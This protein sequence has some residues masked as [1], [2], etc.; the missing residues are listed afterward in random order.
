MGIEG[1]KYINHMLKSMCKTTSMSSVSFAVAVTV[2]D[3]GLKLNCLDD[4]NL[5]S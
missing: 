4:N 2:E 5:D 1:Y 3:L